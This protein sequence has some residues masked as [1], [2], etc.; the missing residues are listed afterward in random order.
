MF[1]ILWFIF[2]E[3]FLEIQI[4]DSFFV[5]YLNTKLIVNNKYPRIRFVYFLTLA[6]SVQKITKNYLHLYPNFTISRTE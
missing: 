3:Y 1:F 5:F 4:L 6:L 2:Y